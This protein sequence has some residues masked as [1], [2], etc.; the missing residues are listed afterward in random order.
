MYFRP[1]SALSCALK[2]TTH[3]Y[4]NFYLQRARHFYP[5][6]VAIHSRGRLLQHDRRL[7]IINAE[8]AKKQLRQILLWPVP[9]WCTWAG[10]QL[11]LDYVHGGGPH[12]VT[13]TLVE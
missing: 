4:Q 8:E 13:A 5:S 1:S 10:V 9:S 11:L 2:L 12:M 6:V 3:T 7:D